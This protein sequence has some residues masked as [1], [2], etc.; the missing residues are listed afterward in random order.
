MIMI[1]SKE[2]KRAVRASSN[3]SS[4]R[5][6]VPI[7]STG[8]R[9]RCARKEGWLMNLRRQTHDFRQ[10]A[11]PGRPPS[12][13]APAVQAGADDEWRPTN[14]GRARHS[15]CASPLLV[16]AHEVSHQTQRAGTRAPAVGALLAP[17][18][19]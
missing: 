11:S 18:L 8:P 6:R 15:S 14:E 17:C 2:A 5:L 10:P 7:V 13:A 12:R 16:V 1:E 9:R 4:Q 19:L 3:S